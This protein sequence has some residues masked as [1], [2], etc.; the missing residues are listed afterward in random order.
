MS[1]LQPWMLV[2]LPVAALPVIIHL[3]NQRRFQ[4]IDWAAMRFLLEANR[5]SRGYARIRQW[6]IL[7]FRVLAIAALVFMI[8][9]PLA[10]G[11]LGVAGGGRPDTTLILL[12]RSA[13]MEQRGGGVRSKLETGVALVAQTLA[14][15]GSSRWVVIDS[16]TNEPRELQ[17]PAELIDSP[18]SQPTSAAADL[19]ALLQTAHDYIK[20]NRSGQTEIWICSDLRA[21]DW[22]AESGRWEGLRNSFQEFKQQLSG[23]QTA[24]ANPFGRLLGSGRRQ[25][26]GAGDGRRA[27]IDR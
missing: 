13:S 27:Q 24:R 10:T 1:F 7:L 22:N 15:L 3:I 26:R 8:S 9:R 14:T 23:V 12:D 19:P 11:W 4:S 16:V 25:S 18:S 17:S 6:L 21:N 2:A 5:M 20:N